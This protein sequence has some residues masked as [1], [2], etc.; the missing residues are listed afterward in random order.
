[1]YGA[2]QPAIHS[3]PL[4]LSHSQV[5]EPVRRSRPLRRGV[6]PA[7][8]SYSLHLPPGPVSQGP[9]EHRPVGAP[10]GAIVGAAVGL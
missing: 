2:S 3:Y 8:G 6:V 7:F 1:M 9:T 4:W 10:D 5:T